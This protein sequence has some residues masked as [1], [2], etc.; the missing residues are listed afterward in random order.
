MIE[1]RLVKIAMTASLAAFALLV[2]IDNVVDYGTN[3]QFVK[4]VFSMDTIFPDSTLRWRAI[5]APALWQGGYAV[6]IAG[7]ALTGLCFAAGTLALLARLRAPAGLFQR[8]KRLCLLGAGL[9]FLVWFLGFMVIG[10]EWFQMWQS[11]TWNGQTPAFHF[12]VTLLGVAIFLNQ[13]DAELPGAATPP[14]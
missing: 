9:G 10:G 8:A 11:S 3:Y 13:P 7:E 4:H 12:Y 14:R 1:V 6:I 2:A 5:T